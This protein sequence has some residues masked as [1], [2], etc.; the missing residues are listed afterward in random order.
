MRTSKDAGTPGGRSIASSSSA[1]HPAGTRRPAPAVGRCAP[2]SP[3]GRGAGA[4]L[5]TRVASRVGR[6]S[7]AARW[8]PDRADSRMSLPDPA[9]VV[10]VGASGS[11]KST[12]AAQRYRAEEVV[13]SDALRGVV[14]SGPHDLDAS[15]DA[16]A[17][18]R[19]GR[20]GP[21]GPPAD[22]RGRHA[23]V[24]RRPAAGLAV[25]GARAAGLPAVARAARD[26]RRGV[27]PPQRRSATV[28][29]PPG[30][31]PGSC[32]V[33]ERWRPRSRTRGGTSSCP[34]PPTRPRRPAP[35]PAE[36]ASGR[37]AHG[38]HRRRGGPAGL[39]VPVGR[40]PAG[41]AAR[42]RPRGRRGRVRR[43]GPDGP[44]DPDPPG[45]PRLGPDPRAVG[46]A[47]RPRGASA[48]GCGSA[49]CAPRSPSAGP[50]SPRRPPPPCPRSPAGGRSSA[51]ARAGGNASTRPS[52]C[53]SRRP[54]AARRAGVL[55][56]GH[57]GPVGAGHQ[58]A[59]G[60]RGVPSRDDVLP[61]AH[62]AHPGGRR[63]ERRAAH[64]ADRGRAR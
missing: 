40:G 29:C 12:W 42:R 20:H 11:G 58:G 31:W 27:P 32:A 38:I 64:P 43:A 7:S 61:A 23:R 8:A 34:S 44:P 33:V 19:G 55:H 4:T 17:A 2:D 3:A 59:R 57:A 36:A 52:A 9:L 21:V 24:R 46:D 10:L 18:A 6:S 22:D 56:P 54:G 25:A 39:P 50:G 13:S 47:R 37:R 49:R 35:A 41:L 45:R 51:S 30:C 63:R 16:F 48:P 14:G 53:R 26:P 1:P 15:A 28:R 62:R 5:A 60:R